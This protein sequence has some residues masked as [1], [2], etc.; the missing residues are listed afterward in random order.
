[1]TS[2]VLLPRAAIALVWFYQG[3]WC[4]LLGRAPHHRK[5]V[6]TAPFLNSSGARQAVMVLGVA[7]CVLAAWVLSGIRAHEAALMQTLLLVSMNTA[8]LLWARRL[9]SD[10]AGMLLQNFVF[11]VLAWVAAG[12]PGFYAG[13]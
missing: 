9:I 4:K 3:F 11:L 10:P 2:S 5:I 12:E 13:V 7:E 8:G 6:G 1:M